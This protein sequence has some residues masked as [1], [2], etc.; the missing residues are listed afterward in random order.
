[1]PIEIPL[2]LEELDYLLKTFGSKTESE[3]LSKMGIE[4]EG[5]ALY[6][7]SKT[8][9]EQNTNNFMSTFRKY[10]PTFE[11]YF[12]VKAL[13]NPHIL[14]LL[15]DNG[16]G[17][18]CS[19]ISELKM[20]NQIEKIH[21]IKCKKIFSS[22][23]TTFEDIA[24]YFTDGITDPSSGIINFDDIDGFNN[25]T[26]F[27][28][29]LKITD[30]EKY[31]KLFPQ[32]VCF[33][34]NPSMG[35]TNSEVKSNVLGGPDSKFGI[36]VDKIL[37]AYSIAQ[38]YGIK[39]FGIHVMTGSCIL[40]TD[41]FTQLVDAIY[42]VV[43]SLFEKLKI[44]IKFINLGGGIGIPYKQDTAP[45]DINLLAKNIYQIVNDNNKKYS[46]DFNP[47]IM[48]ENGRYITGP[49]GWLVTRCGSIKN[50]YNNTFVGLRA[51]MSNL[52]RPGMYGSYHHITIPRLLDVKETSKVNVVGT[53]CE[54]NDWF[55]KDRM[56]P[57]G[58]KI[59][60]IVVIHD[61]GAHSHSMG[62]QYN[63]KLR[64]GEVLF[65]DSDFKLIR[66]AENYNDYSSSIVD[67]TI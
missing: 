16:L 42:T 7:Y 47:E 45:I 11:Q 14:K 27:F 28:D 20:V 10:F 29:Y 63:G 5:D 18:D 17:F 59:N 54:N 44:R 9:I 2:S 55:A 4:S 32:L 60:D 40:D 65:S 36:Y 13:P 61:C 58:I 46:L 57:E 48:M 12:A 52:M 31:A 6:L 1:M 37:T 25:M 21:N 50:N 19:S 39:D 62:F 22:N 35:T 67:Y 34:L 24:Y 23:Y 3:T 8:M 64:C 51:C 49:Y 56:L 41:Y 66:R 30:Y 15:H 26:K 53:L 33:R 38:N 43:H